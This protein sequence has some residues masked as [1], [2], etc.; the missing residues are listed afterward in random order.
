M[1][2]YAKQRKL[3]CYVI[4]QGKIRYFTLRNKMSGSFKFSLGK[5]LE[6]RIWSTLVVFSHKIFEYSD[7][8]KLLLN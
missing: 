8:S 7:G 3:D 1:K 6:D 5:L 4:G 2:L